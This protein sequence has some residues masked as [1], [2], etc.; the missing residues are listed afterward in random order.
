MGLCQTSQQVF[1]IPCV[2]T[3]QEVPPLPPKVPPTGKAKHKGVTKGGLGFVWSL[4]FMKGTTAK[5]LVFTLAVLSLVPATP[6]PTATRSVRAVTDLVEGMGGAANKVL[7]SG[8]NVT[9]SAARV[10]GAI[11]DGTLSLGE[12]A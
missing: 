9:D 6:F 1:G 11:A 8:A 4:F 5:N 3:A 10:A 2:P 12:V 7:A